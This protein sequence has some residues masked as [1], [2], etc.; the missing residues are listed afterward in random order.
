M[1]KSPK[2]KPAAKRQAD[3][4]PATVPFAA[5]PAGET[6]GIDE[7][8]HRAVWTDRML[9]TLLENKVRGG[10]WHTLI[11]KVFCRLNLFCSAHKVLGKKGADGTANTSLEINVGR[12]PTLRSVGSSACV[13]PTSVSSN[14]RE[15]TDW[16]AVCGKIART[17]RREGRPK[18]IGRSYPYPAESDHDNRG[19]SDHDYRGRHGWLMCGG[20]TGGLFSV[21]SWHQ[22]AGGCLA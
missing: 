18:P 21:P 14:P 6:P 2:R 10:R 12:T 13:N 15:P 22:T 8:A 9:A 1:S 3:S 5:I 19:S 4:I 17:V 16:R 7:W 20:S 11:D